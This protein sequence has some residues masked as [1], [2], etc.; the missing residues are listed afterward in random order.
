[1]KA[2][3]YVA[4]QSIEQVVSLLGLHGE[5]ARVL[6]GGTDLI[7]QLREG[8]KQAALLVDIKAIPEVNQLGYNPIQGLLIGAA[9]P[10]WRICN[11][12]E[13]IAHYPGLVDAAGLIGGTQIQSRASLGGNLC[14]ASPAADSPRVR[15]Q[16]RGVRRLRGST[17]RMYRTPR[18]ETRRVRPIRRQVG[19]SRLRHRDVL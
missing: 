11:E 8:R 2:F 1:M 19:R 17:R 5:N 12:P 10:C 15:P 14:N 9:V 6:S 13:V 18:R 16:S 3:D 4:A 7:V